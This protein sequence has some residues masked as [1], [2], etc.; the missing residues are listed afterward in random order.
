MFDGIVQRM[1]SLKLTKLR[2]WRKLLLLK[3]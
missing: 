3:D 1:N 2:W